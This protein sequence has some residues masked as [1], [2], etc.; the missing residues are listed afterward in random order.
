MWGLGL[1]LVFAGTVYEVKEADFSRESGVLAASI[2][3]GGLFA[4]G[5]LAS[6]V[7][8]SVD[9]WCCISCGHYVPRTAP[10]IPKRH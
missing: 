9:V 7:L 1:F 6:L 10:A 2:A 3:I 8:S 5:L 4:F